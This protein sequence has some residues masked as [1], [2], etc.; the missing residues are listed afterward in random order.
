MNNMIRIMPG[1]D[2]AVSALNAERMKLE[3]ISQNIANANVTRTEEGGP[4]QRKD[5]V[6]ESFLHES[7]NKEGSQ[8]DAPMMVKVGGIETDETPGVTIHDPSHPDAD[9]DG[10]VQLPNVN[11]HKEMVDMIQASRAYEANLSS[12]KFARSMA[13]QTLNIGRS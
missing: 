11:I 2:T 3:I 6:F 5:V 9:D 13:V 8:S 7:L 10:N 1:A 4:Y 12:I